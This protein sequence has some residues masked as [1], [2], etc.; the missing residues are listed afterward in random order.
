MRGWRQIVLAA[1]SCPASLAAAALPTPRELLTQA[2]FGDRAREPALARVDAA[3]AQ[4]EATLR[5]APGDREAALMDA[6]AICYR[7]KL[8]HSRADA[9]LGRTLLEKLIAREPRDAEAALALGAWHVGAVHGAGAL[10][11][12]AVLGARKQVGFDT[13][14]RAVTLGGG[15]PFFTGVAGLLRLELDPADRRGRALVEAA[16]RSEPSTPLDRILQRSAAAELVPLRA[17]DAPRAQALASDLLPFGKL[18]H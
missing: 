14:D 2:S 10:L 8:A 16:A 17:G 11:A 9:L 7:A 1:L 5:T 6:M 12:R 3:A 4:A 18:R 15:K 13:L